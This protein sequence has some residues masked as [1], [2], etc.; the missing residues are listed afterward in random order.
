MDFGFGLTVA[1]PEPGEAIDLVRPVVLIEPNHP[2]Q[3][4]LLQ[5]SGREGP[6]REIRFEL[7]LE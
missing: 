5:L 7:H 1:A 3:L 6:P 4:R 2:H